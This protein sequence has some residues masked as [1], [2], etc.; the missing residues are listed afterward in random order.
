MVIEEK[1][2]FFQYKILLLLHINAL[3]VLFSS[4]IN[5]IISIIGIFIVFD[6]HLKNT[7]KT[8]KFEIEKAI[9]MDERL[10]FITSISNNFENDEGE[11]YYD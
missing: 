11:H 1:L 4:E 2:H 6:T 8:Y 10:Y 9:S 5:P 7:E 3:L